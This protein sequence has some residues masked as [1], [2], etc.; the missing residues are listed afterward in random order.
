MLLLQYY[1]HLPLGR[2]RPSRFQGNRRLVE[3]TIGEGTDDEETKSGGSGDA[4]EDFPS[5][6]VEGVDR[7]GVLTIRFT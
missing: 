5:L 7:L 6:V 3:I 1:L 4:S 2:R